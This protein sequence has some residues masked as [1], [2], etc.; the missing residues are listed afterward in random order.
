MMPFAYSAL[1]FAVFWYIW[2]PVDE[3]QRT[4]R[5]DPIHQYWGDLIF[6]AK[7]LGEGQLA[8]WNPYDRAGAPIY[9][10]PQPGILYPPNWLL[11]GVGWI[12]GGVGYVLM[13]AKILGHWIFGAI[14]MHLFARRRGCPEPAAYVGGVLFAF[15]SP[16]IRYG[17]NALNWT[18]AW[19]PW[20]LLAVDWFCERPSLRRA[21]VLGTAVAMALLSGAPAVF[22]YLLLVAVPYGMYLLWGRLRA[23]ALPLAVAVGAA[24]LWLLPLVLATLEQMPHSVRENRDL[25]FITWSAFKQE[26]LINVLVPR[27]GGE[28]IYYGLIPLAAIGIALGLREVGR[29]RVLAACGAAGVLLG[30]GWHLDVLGALASFAP[31]F[32]L[33][34]VAHRYLY[35]TAAAVAAAAALGLGAAYLLEDRGVRRRLARGVLAIGGG[36]VVTLLIASVIAWVA[37]NA[38]QFR[39]LA[40]ALVAAAIGT[41]LLVGV[42]TLNGRR[43]S[44]A[45][46]VVAAFVAFDLWLANAHVHDPGLSA[47]PRPLRDD[48]IARLEGVREGAYRVFDREY[49]EFRPGVRLGIRDFSGYEDDPLG[50]SRYTLYRERALVRGELLGHANI[51]Y[52]LRGEHPWL[53][54]KPPRGARV[55]EL[56]DGV[57]ELREVAPAVMYVAAP[58][59]V[60]DIQAALARLATMVP[61]KGA[62]VEG[63]VLRGPE[64]APITAGQILSLEPNRLVAEIETPA[65]GA[66]IIAEAYYPKWRA[67]VNGEPAEIVPANGMFRAVSVPGPGI[68]RIEM[69]LRPVRYLAALPAYGL[70][71]LLLLAALITGVR[72]R[73]AGEGGHR[74]VASAGRS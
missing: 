55:E 40:H 1:T 67:T 2:I 31:P 63:E 36:I 53:S 70:A 48:T 25:S 23:T 34:R 37:G 41:A 22:L 50:L 42:L 27:L 8:L 32:G 9:G 3:L 69:E 16:A 72:S 47:K 15:A 54:L 59:R 51:R 11:I 35:V 21:V 65:A 12:A 6:Q 60:D 49:L 73:R 26:H 46:W 28:N 56:E 58:E 30:L 64:D 20:V 52:Y 74:P 17:G 5:Y 13:E 68:H 71:W 62:V 19:I 4:R 44:A 33:F 29:V 43:R 39:G 18:Y 57:Y 45:L 14:G 66:V 38:P 10:D 61:G 7:T 24:A